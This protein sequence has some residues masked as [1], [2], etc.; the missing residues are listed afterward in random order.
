M[1]KNGHDQIRE[2]ENEIFADAAIEGRLRTR[3]AGKTTQRERAVI[4]RQLDLIGRRIE[5]ATC[6]IRAIEDFVL[7][8]GRPVEDGARLSHALKVRRPD[9]YRP[10][11]AI[12]PVKFY[13]IE[14]V[15]SREKLAA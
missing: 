4:N 15:E 8:S 3:L 14:I 1:K 2:L 13:G 10:I 5:R 7:D 9:M 6:E 11:A 12:R